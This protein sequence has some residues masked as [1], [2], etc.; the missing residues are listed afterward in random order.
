MPTSTEFDYLLDPTIPHMSVDGAT[1]GGTSHMVNEGGGGPG[2]TTGGGG[3]SASELMLMGQE[4][5]PSVSGG[6]SALLPGGMGVRGGGSNAGSVGMSGGVGGDVVMGGGLGAL[7]AGVG[8][9]GL[10]GG[11]HAGMVGHVGN[12]GI[13]GD[14]SDVGRR[15]GIVERNGV[16]NVVEG[17]VQ[18]RSRTSMNAEEKAA[19]DQK[20]IMRNRELAR[21]SNERRKG[22]IKA[23]E[24]ELQETK[25]TVKRLQDSIR[26]LENENNG[27]K[28]LLEKH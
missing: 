28:N 11:M 24:N 2:G 25:A 19:K 9:A 6:V 20:R 17:G 14:R 22:R 3:G 1:S 8:S 21:V 16:V 12:A 27:L 10:G 5:L 26:E 23:M 18:K 13:V 4:I 7:S 15:R